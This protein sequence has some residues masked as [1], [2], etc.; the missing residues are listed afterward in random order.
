MAPLGEVD[1]H[2]N[3]SSFLKGVMKMAG[4]DINPFGEHDKTDAQPD[5]NETI[6]S[7]LDGV[8]GVPSWEP[9]CE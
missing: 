1:T 3:S 9:D 8:I 7:V 5:T 6:P 4:G 2:C